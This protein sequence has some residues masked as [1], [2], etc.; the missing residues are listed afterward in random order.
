M[1][2]GD[3]LWI[4]D[5]GWVLVCVWFITL[6]VSFFMFL[7]LDVSGLLLCWVGWF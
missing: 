7:L 5:F 1:V 3:L 2:G 4:W 6:F